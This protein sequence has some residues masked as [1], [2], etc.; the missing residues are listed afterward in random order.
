MKR[1]SNFIDRTGL[2]YGRLTVISEAGFSQKH[3][4]TFWN[5]IC[6]C[7]KQCSIQGKL[8]SNGTTKSC[9]CLRGDVL[10]D[11]L[12]GKRFGSFTVVKFV[13]KNPGGQAARR[14]LCRCDC[15]SDRIYTVSHINSGQVK[16]CG[17]LTNH[18]IGEKNSTHGAT[19][20]GTRTKEYRTWKAIMDRCYLKTC[21]SYRHYGARGI[22]VCERWLESF[23]NFLEDMGSAPQGTSI[24]RIKNHIGY[25]KEN[26]CWA[27]SDIQ[28]RNK[29]TNIFA[30]HEGKTQ[31]CLDWARE[32]NIPH[33]TVLRRIKKGRTIAQIKAEFHA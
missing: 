12:T 18:L 7:G 31:C 23:E 4:R 11:D 5:C 3:Q 1:P 14:F 29:R 24:E 8:L 30:T 10:R 25:F 33:W 9:G 26:C 2:K 27:T 17:C 32:L 6:E 13:D 16:S 22:T 28:A 19:R 15:G 20:G 21:E